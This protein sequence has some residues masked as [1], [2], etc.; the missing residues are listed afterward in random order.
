[1]SL[2]RLQKATSAGARKVRS[3]TG[4]GVSGGMGAAAWADRVEDRARHGPQPCG[5]KRRHDSLVWCRI[6]RL[7]VRRHR[8]DRGTIPP[9]TY[10][11]DE[12]FLIIFKKRSA[13]FFAKKNKKLL[14]VG[15]LAAEI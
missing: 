14:S 3:V 9:V 1:M 15:V 6:G 8:G 4:D 13:F 11:T 2:F 10:L 7:S 12:K 5:R